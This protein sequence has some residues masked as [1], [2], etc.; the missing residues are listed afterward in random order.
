[1]TQEL[2]FPLN[3]KLRNRNNRIMM[4]SAINFLSKLVLSKPR[5][6]AALIILVLSKLKSAA[7]VGWRMGGI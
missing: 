4:N 5:T 2:I 6:K 7:A 3:D 1:M